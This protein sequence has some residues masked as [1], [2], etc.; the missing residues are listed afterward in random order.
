LGRK[1]NGNAD[2]LPPQR[3]HAKGLNLPPVLLAGDV[4]GNPWNRR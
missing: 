3:R 2:G 1:G 4:W